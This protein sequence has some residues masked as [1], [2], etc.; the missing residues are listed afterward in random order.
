MVGVYLGASEA[1]GRPLKLLHRDT[2]TPQRWMNRGAW[3]WAAFNGASL[4]IGFTTR[5]GFAL[6]YVVPAASLLAGSPFAGAMIY[7]VY[8]TVRSGSALLLIAAAR[9]TD[10]E[11]V[12]DRLLDSKLSTKKTITGPLLL[13]ISL[14]TVI[15]AGV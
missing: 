12:M 3:T 2:E 13:A 14:A 8:G 10:L 6:W 5:I 1:L 7:G 4:G 15:V 11:T 9:R